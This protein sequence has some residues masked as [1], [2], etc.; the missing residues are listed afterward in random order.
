[1]RP[2]KNYE[3]PP[4]SVG[5]PRPPMP[6]DLASTMIVEWDHHHERC[7]ATATVDGATLEAHDSGYWKIVVPGHV[8]ENGR[9]AIGVDAAKRAAVLALAT[10][11]CRQAVELASCF[12]ECSELDEYRRALGMTVA[13]APTTP[14]QPEARPAI[15]VGDRV[16]VLRSPSHRLV[17]I[18][19]EGVVVHTY[20]DDEWITADLEGYPRTHFNISEIEVIRPALPT[21]EVAWREGFMGTIDMMIG[22]QQAARLFATTVGSHRVGDWHG[23]SRFQCGP[24]DISGS[25]PTVEQAKIDAEA[26]WRK[27]QG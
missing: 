7:T 8:V 15:K 17:H 4:A 23:W 10:H 24:A 22:G 5:T 1:M 27:A 16:R 18:G 3:P 14:K 20:A 13:P 9:A 11:L 21:F 25:A 19:A 2:T 6:A 12:V 26:A